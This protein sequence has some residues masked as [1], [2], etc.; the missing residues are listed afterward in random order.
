MMTNIRVSPDHNDYEVWCWIIYSLL[1]H[2]F[3]L[4]MYYLYL[5]VLCRSRWGL[6]CTEGWRMWKRKCGAMYRLL[7]VSS[8][9]KIYSHPKVGM[10]SGNRLSGIEVS[11]HRINSW[12]WGFYCTCKLLALS[13]LFRH[14]FLGGVVAL[15][16]IPIWDINETTCS[17]QTLAV[18]NQTFYWSCHEW[19][20]DDFNLPLITRLARIPNMLVMKP[21]AA[22]N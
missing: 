6:I 5:I 2:L 15:G 18:L 9:M 13:M 11:F 20:K 14:Y 3:D 16:R 21:G 17:P 4:Q 19:Y 8:F 1:V 10:E 22:K 12:S 7:H